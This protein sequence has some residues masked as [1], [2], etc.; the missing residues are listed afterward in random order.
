[1]LD[2][3]IHKD[4]EYID[5]VLEVQNGRKRKIINKRKEKRK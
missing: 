4:P 1:M 3:S 2:S 5:P